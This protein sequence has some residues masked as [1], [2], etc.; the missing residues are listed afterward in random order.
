LKKVG[1]S[2]ISARPRHPPHA[3]NRRGAGPA[4]RRYGSDATPS[5]RDRRQPRRRRPRRADLRP[6]RLAHHAQSRL[7]AQSHADLAALA[8]PE[9]TPAENV[10]RHLRGDWRS[11]AVFE[12][13]DDIVDAACDARR[14]LAA[15]PE[16]VTSI[17]MRHWAQSASVSPYDP[18]V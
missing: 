6:R 17:G 1:F 5:R 16:V 3:R 8:R 7:P 11:D 18:L 4:F 13:F 12:T 9:L 2:R 10:R 15:T 14:N